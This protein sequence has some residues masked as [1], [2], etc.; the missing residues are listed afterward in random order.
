L[1]ALDFVIHPQDEY[2]GQPMHRTGQYFVIGI[3][4]SSRVENSKRYRRYD[5]IF[6]KINV[7]DKDNDY[8]NHKKKQKQTPYLTDLNQHFIQVR[9]YE[10][11]TDHEWHDQK[12]DPASDQYRIRYARQP[13]NDHRNYIAPVPLVTQVEYDK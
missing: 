2:N 12:N 9:L 5:P 7:I 6:V 1:A 3:I 10:I 11:S 13:K 8:S 4:I